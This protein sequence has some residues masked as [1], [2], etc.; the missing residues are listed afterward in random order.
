MKIIIFQ[1][2]LIVV[3]AEE[4]CI[5]V[6]DGFWLD[7]TMYWKIIKCDDNIYVTSYHDNKFSV[8]P[9]LIFFECPNS[10]SNLHNFLQFSN[11]SNFESVTRIV[12][13]N[14]ELPELFS[15]L[16]VQFPKLVT[17]S[18]QNTQWTKKFFD[19]ATKLKKILVNVMNSF[20]IE[21]LPFSRMLYLEYILL[22]GS[23]SV[24]TTIKDRLKSTYRKALKKDALADN[25]H[26]INVAMKSCNI[27]T[28]PGS[29][30]GNSSNVEYID[31]SKNEI[32]HVPNTL[33]TKLT[34]LQA[35]NFAGNQ[36]ASIDL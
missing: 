19:K 5:F 32:T 1:I 21:T 11:V 30:F 26:L 7:T 33:F 27:E 29:L 22:N 8:K 6:N 3:G 31:F 15:M 18:I 9:V 14:C 24:S 23:G 36:I 4:K 35:I 16:E 2:F 25:S 20:D 12:V 10:A 13:H 17:F 34:K 28:L